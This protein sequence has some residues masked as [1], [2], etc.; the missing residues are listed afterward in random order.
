MSAQEHIDDSVLALFERALLVSE[1]DR[2]RFVREEAGDNRALAETVSALLAHDGAPSPLDRNPAETAHRT[3]EGSIPPGGKIGRYLVRSVLGRGGMGLVYLAEHEALGTTA[4]IKVLPDAWVSP[5]RRARFA[6]EARTL[7]RLTHPFIARLYEADSL[8]D[9]TPYF[10][11]EFVEGET[12]TDYCLRRNLALDDRL[13]VFRDVCEA[14]QY[15]HQQAIVHRDLKPSNVLVGPDSSV[16]LLDFGI[17]ANLDQLEDG[18]VT[19]TRVMTPAYA[20]PEQAAGGPIGVYTDVYA[21]GVILFELLTGRR[22][23]AP[24]HERPS[25]AVKHGSAPHPPPGVSSSAWAD[26][27][28][29][30]LKAAHPDPA[31][32]YASV[33][34]LIRDIDHFLHGEPLEARPDGL[35]YRAGKFARRHRH[36]FAASTIAILSIVALV[37]FYTWQLRTAR[38]AALAEAERT[39]RIQEFMMGLFTG[40][41]EAGALADTL[42]VV[43]LLHRGVAEARVLDAMPDVQADLFETLGSLFQQLGELDRADSMLETSLSVRRQHFGQ[44][45]PTVAQSLVQLGLLRLEQ[46]RIDEADSLVQAALDLARRDRAASS[47][48]LAQAVGAYGLVLQAQ[49]EYDRAAEALEEAVRM[50]A[51]Q[52]EQ[53]FELSGTIS[54][55]AN[56]HFYAGRYALSDSLNQLALAM[57][58]EIY[59]RRHPEVAS[60]LVNLA[61]TRFNLGELSDAERLNRQAL[62]IYVSYYGADHP[63]TASSMVMLAQVLVAQDRLSEAM[64]LLEPALAVRERAF[65]PD[66]PRVASTLNEMG[67]VALKQEDLD[68]AEAHFQRMVDIYR[69]AYGDDHYLIGIA[70]SNLSSVYRNRG[71]LARCEAVLREAVERFTSSL[72]PDHMHTGVARLK[73]GRALLFQEKYAEAEVELRTGYEVLE[74]QLNPSSAWL[75]EGAKDLT[76]VY[77]ALGDPGRAAPYRLASAGNPEGQSN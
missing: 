49:G 77:E 21:L 68:L 76:S 64:T 54:D 14:V 41:D 34:G 69:S 73:L 12:L 4:A 1:A 53:S 61:A 66:H 11:M 42:R 56:T 8:P 70:L 6:R 62:E 9:G 45:D 26:L 24:A 27:D 29:I 15:A 3:L 74:G 33:E 48:E 57:D 75:I 44:S 40:D 17:A 46:A 51:A 67:T 39:Q 7:A 5:E 43:T 60:V 32:R 47:P 55:L 72:S 20:A 28:E 22:P 25:R 65:G 63:I 10:V 13:H 37:S 38:D 58:R 30:S 52:S 71:D 23:G 31:R 2:D 16:R 18:T 59:G 35:V 19:R 36:A 50:F